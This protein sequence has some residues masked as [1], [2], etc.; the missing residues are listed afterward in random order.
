M[1][2]QSIIAQ[3]KEDL[4]ADSKCYWHEECRQTLRLLKEHPNK[5][6]YHVIVMTM[7]GVQREY[8][9]IS[10]IGEYLKDYYSVYINPSHYN[11][12]HK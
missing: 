2:K 1:K 12:V 9:T 4:K 8:C 10:E 11:K 3:W 5:E 7:E 6:G